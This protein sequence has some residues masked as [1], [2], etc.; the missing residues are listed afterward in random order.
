MEKSK[1]YRNCK[2]LIDNN[3]YEY[4]NMIDIIGTFLLNNTITSEEYTELKNLMDNKLT[5]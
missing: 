2:K 3:R 1:M 4:N 5:N